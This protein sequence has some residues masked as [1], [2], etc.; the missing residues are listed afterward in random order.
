[1]RRHPRSTPARSAP[2]RSAAA[3]TLLE[4]VVALTITATI[5]TL[6]AAVWSQVAGW[7][8]D[9]RGL[10]ETLRADR[11][12]SLAQRQ[13]SERVTIEDADFGTITLVSFDGAH[14]R[15]VTA[16]P[17]LLTDAPLVVASYVI[18]PPL[19]EIVTVERTP[20]RVTYTEWRVR[21]PG[22]PWRDLG[23]DPEQALLEPGRADRVI[24]IEDARGMGFQSWRD[25]FEL[26]IGERPGWQ[27]IEGPGFRPPSKDLELDLGEERG[28]VGEPGDD[29]RSGRRDAEPPPGA[30]LTSRETDD[31]AGRDGGSSDQ[32]RLPRAIRLTGVWRGKEVEWLLVDVVSP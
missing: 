8:D 22:Q 4:M 7:S 27:T 13:W 28:E 24:A 3:F 6:L 11:L 30:D 9:Q 15:F 26:D 29:T 25:A 20:Q 2:T 21:S 19:D 14:L 1:M 31:G 18:D 12:A 17:V 10:H 32:D 5:L 16:E 23:D